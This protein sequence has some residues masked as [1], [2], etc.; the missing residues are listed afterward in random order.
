[1]S[2]KRVVFEGTYSG[3]THQQ[4]NDF[5]T[6]VFD[7]LKK[8]SVSGRFIAQEE[9]IW[10]ELEGTAGEIAKAETYLTNSPFPSS[11]TKT[12]DETITSLNFVKL[13]GYYECE[14]PLCHTY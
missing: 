7:T 3:K 2:Y 5:R 6:A 8:G 13:F 4:I 1:M 10:L 9:I 12:Q 11:M 14:S